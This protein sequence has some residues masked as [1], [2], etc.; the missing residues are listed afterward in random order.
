VQGTS[1]DLV[2][3]LIIVSL[4]CVQ[5]FGNVSQR[6][7]DDARQCSE[8]EKGEAYPSYN[9]ASERKGDSGHNDSRALEK[10]KECGKK[11]GYN[12]GWSYTLHIRKRGKGVRGFIRI[13]Y[14]LD[15]SVYRP[16]IEEV[17]RIHESMALRRRILFFGTIAFLSALLIGSFI[18]ILFF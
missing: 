2:L 12:E 10:I 11:E 16:F 18:V 1:I 8:N 7:F 13:L 9:V 5:R 3:L 15:I 6:V 17:E 14:M 4:V